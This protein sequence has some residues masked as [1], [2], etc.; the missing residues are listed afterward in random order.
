[1]TGPAPRRH[2]YLFIGALLSAAWLVLCARYIDQAIGWD[3]FAFVLPHELGAML[4]GEMLRVPLR[5]PLAAAGLPRARARPCR[6]HGH[7]AGPVKALTFPSAEASQSV[8]AAGAML[9]READAVRAASAEGISVLGALGETLGG[10]TAE[11]GAATTAAGATLDRLGATLSGEIEAARGTADRLEAARTDWQGVVDGHGAAMRGRGGRAARPARRRARP[12]GAAPRRG[13]RSA[14]RRRPSGWPAGSPTIARSGRAWSSARSSRLQTT[15][16]ASAERIGALMQERTAGIG[17]AIEL[18]VDQGQSIMGDLAAAERRFA[19][20]A[21]GSAARIDT[22]LGRIAETLG[23]ASDGAIE[24]GERLREALAEQ[25]ET[26]ATA[27]DEAGARLA[28]RLATAS[29]GLAGALERVPRRAS[30]ASRPPRRKPCAL[31]RA[32]ETTGETRAEFERRLAE[33]EQRLDE[34]NALAM[35]RAAEASERLAALALE[36]RARDRAAV[37]GEFGVAAADGERN[38]GQRRGHRRAGLRR[39]ATAVGKAV[40]EAQ[41]HADGLGTALEVRIADMMH[42]GRKFVGEGAA[43]GDQSNTELEAALA[44]QKRAGDEVRRCA[45]IPSFA[46][47]STRLAGTCPKPAA[48]WRQRRASRPAASRRVCARGDAGD[49]ERERGAVAGRAP[50]PRPCAPNSTPCRPPAAAWWPTARRPA[51]ASPTVSRVFCSACSMRATACCRRSSVPSPA[52][53]TSP[54]R[55]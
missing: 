34:A 51:P 15:A 52:G 29:D 1:M 4:A 13:A 28:R 5:V 38:R 48:A 42:V 43:L 40:A 30:S 24:R 2:W 10:R 25:V 35:T 45:S 20:L 7:A 46:S 33:R 49:A 31:I 9:R 14:G 3:G 22:M 26:S 39:Q 23:T 16:S 37:P 19:D 36:P 12:L 32:V 6:S 50:G 44:A 17:G 47:A 53:P 41:T 18:A 8:E 27:T 11:L 54:A 55:G 21:E